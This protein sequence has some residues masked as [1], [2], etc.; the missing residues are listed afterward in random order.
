MI[1]GG[2]HTSKCAQRSRRIHSVSLA[3]KEKILRL[4]SL[5][6]D[7]KYLD[8]FRQFRYTISNAKQIRLRGAGCIRLRVSLLAL[9]RE[10]DTASTVGGKD[11]NTEKV[12][13]CILRR[14]CNAIFSLWKLR[15]NRLRLG[16]ES[17]A[18]VVLFE[19]QEIHKVFLCFPNF[20]LSQNLRLPALAD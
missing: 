13:H 3:G 1:A 20:R 15:I 2:N 4:A 16:S 19:K 7:D 6:Q 17:F 5:A 9:T 10:P 11:Q 8:I 18:P 14:I 12:S